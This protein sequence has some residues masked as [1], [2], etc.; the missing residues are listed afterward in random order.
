MVVGRLRRCGAAERLFKS[1]PLPPAVPSGAQ[2]SSYSQSDFGPPY[3]LGAT[4][5]ESLIIGVAYVDQNCSAFF[6]AVEHM[7]R[8][9][10]LIQSGVTTAATQTLAVM[11]AAEKSALAIARV[12]AAF[13]IT[14]VL[15]EQYRQQFTFAEHSSELRSLVSQAMTAQRKEF[16]SL[17]ARNAIELDV[18]VIAIVKRYAENCTLATIRE[19]WNAALAKAVRE[20]VR[21]VSTRAGA[22][23]LAGER[24]RAIASQPANV[25]GVN[26]YVVQ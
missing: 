4:P 8:K 21:P 25:L 19:Y 23:S 22:R 3:R 9:T 24:A 17:I 1:G 13:E 16:S 15:L 10:A 18:E 11:A 6:D 26:Q 7:N 12:A 5:R 2:L 20:G 14:K